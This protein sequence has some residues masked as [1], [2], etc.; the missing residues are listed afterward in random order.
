M[1]SLIPTRHVYFS[2]TSDNPFIPD[3]YVKQLRDDLD[4]KLAMRMLDGIWL[5]IGTDV[6]YHAFKTEN[7][8]RDYDY[9]IELT[10]PIYLAFDF[11][12]SLGKPMSMCL[13]Q[14]LP[15]K[16]EFHFFNEAI[17]EGA[18]TEELCEEIAG[19]GLLDYD[20]NYIVH[21]DAT[22]GARSSKSKS[23]DYD[24]ISKCLANYRNPN[25]QKLDYRVDVPASN[26]PVRKRH[27]LVNAYCKNANG[28]SRLFIYRPCKTLLEGMRLT[29][30]RKGGSYVEDDSKHY[31]HVTTA[32]GYHV[33]RCHNQRDINKPRATLRNI[34]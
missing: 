23:S 2:I 31:Q 34:R 28:K 32:L 24:L 4:P 16:D 15:H 12:I 5:E 30:L 6:I 19:R 21:G 29:C 1:S 26:P 33:L 22:G 14:Y 13:S 20:T 27:N 11:N 25:G 3:W 9:V 7:N 18:S 17:V 8:F 10:Q